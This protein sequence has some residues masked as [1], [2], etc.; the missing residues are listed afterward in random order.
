MINFFKG[1]LPWKNF[2]VSKHSA[3]FRKLGELK[4]RCTRGQLF[5]GIPSFFKKYM[6]YSGG[7]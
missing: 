5:D 7:L 4:A 6:E 3:R 1:Y 2:D